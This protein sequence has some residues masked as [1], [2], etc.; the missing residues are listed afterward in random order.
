MSN[1]KFGNVPKRTKTLQ[2][3]LKNLAFMSGN[4]SVVEK[5]ILKFQVME[6]SFVGGGGGGVVFSEIDICFV[7]E[8][9]GW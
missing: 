2:Y 1:K 6:A 9:V 3:G 5:I 8:V 7:G 4:P